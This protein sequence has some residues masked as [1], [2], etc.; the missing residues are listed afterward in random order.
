MTI[1]SYILISLSSLIIAFINLSPQFGSNPNKEQKKYYSTFP[2]Y[3]NNEFNNQENTLMVTAD[4]P[5]SNFFKR[6]SN[7]IP[8][9]NIVSKKTD[10]IM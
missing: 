9:E 1:L 2:N 7:R 6:D 10:V 3:K 4:M 8:I 5:M